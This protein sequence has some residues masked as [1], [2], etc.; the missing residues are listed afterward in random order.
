[1]EATQAADKAIDTQ[2]AYL[3]VA[4][5]FNE[6]Y[7]GYLRETVAHF[8]A[9]GVRP[10][11][12][13]QLTQ[14]ALSVIQRT[15]SV[16]QQPL[17][18]TQRALSVT[19][20]ALSVTQAALSVTQAAL[21]VTQQPLSVTQAALS[22]TQEADRVCGRQ[23]VAVLSGARGDALVRDNA[24]RILAEV[25]TL[26]SRTSKQVV[27]VGHSKGGLD[28]A[29]ALALYQDRLQVRSL[30][31]RERERDRGPGGLTAHVTI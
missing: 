12:A 11:H 29:A 19:Q 14:R 28:C 2:F 7:P 10:P 5:L 8:T 16:I 9:A 6:F 25:E 27:L 15:L 23:A 22:A 24:V 20:R 17:S 13:Y 4:G 18:V 3:F 26:A 30:G 31:E 1:L 21:S